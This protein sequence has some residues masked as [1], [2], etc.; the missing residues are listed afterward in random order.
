MTVIRSCLLRHRH[1]SSP[2]AQRNTSEIQERSFDLFLRLRMAKKYCCNGHSRFPGGNSGLVCPKYFQGRTA[3]CSALTY[4][5]GSSQTNA[6]A[7]II[8]C[9]KK[10]G[11]P[12]SIHASLSSALARAVSISILVRFCQLVW[13]FIASIEITGTS[14][15]TIAKLLAK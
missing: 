13:S 11:P 4:S 12:S 9:G 7:R 15:R 10:L 6:S 2:F 14:G 5:G 8:A 3:S 1:F